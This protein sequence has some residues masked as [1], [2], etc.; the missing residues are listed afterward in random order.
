MCYY[1]NNIGHSKQIHRHSEEEHSITVDRTSWLDVSLSRFRSS[2]IVLPIDLS[3][4]YKQQI[5]APVRVYE[6]DKNGNPIGRYITSPNDEDHYAHSRNY[7]EIALPLAA[8]LSL[9]YDL[10]KIL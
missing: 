10:G 1:G 6:K 8:N 5:K 9:A 4:E 2:R 7:A 3:L